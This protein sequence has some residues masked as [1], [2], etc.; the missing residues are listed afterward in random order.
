MAGNDEME[1]HA[2]AAAAFLGGLASA[3]RMKILCQLSGGERSVGALVAAT[4]IPQSSMSQHLAKL[5]AEGI[6]G[7]RREH[8]TVFYSISNPLALSV[9]SVLAAH[10]CK[11]GRKRK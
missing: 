4:G 8:R 6:V 7:S 9:M 5:K 11:K 1:K 10:Y 3:P 2:A